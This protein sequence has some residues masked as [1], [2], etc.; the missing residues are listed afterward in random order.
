MEGGVDREAEEIALEECCE[1]RGE[2]VVE[3]Y[4]HYVENNGKGIRNSVAIVKKSSKIVR[5]CG[6]LRGGESS[7][8]QNRAE[9]FSHHTC[10]QFFRG[11][12]RVIHAGDTHGG[13]LGKRKI[14][15]WNEDLRHSREA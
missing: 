6:M 11:V 1:A 12:I 7:G 10:N 13:E 3:A 8:R 14:K 9:G 15:D 5:V 4:Q 2:I